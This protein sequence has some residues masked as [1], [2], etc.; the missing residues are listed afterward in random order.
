LH[1]EGSISKWLFHSCLG[2]E[3][4]SIEIHTGLF[5]EH[6]VF[7]LLEKLV[8]HPLNLNIC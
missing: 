3:G 2:V 4:D 1:M 6:L 7:Y 8:P 5:V